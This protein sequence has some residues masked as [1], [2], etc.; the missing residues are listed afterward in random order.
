[1]CSVFFSVKVANLMMVQHIRNAEA[2]TIA[3]PGLEHVEDMKQAITELCAL[4]TPEQVYPRGYRWPS[5]PPS[6]L[7]E[8]SVTLTEWDETI[9][10]VVQ[11]DSDMTSPRRGV[12]SRAR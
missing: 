5:L 1:V 11:N 6:A 8:G 2:V 3:T 10:A 9:S 4:I 12:R 7:G